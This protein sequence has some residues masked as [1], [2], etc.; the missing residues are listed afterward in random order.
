M[1]KAVLWAKGREVRSR[2]A[3]CDGLPMFDVTGSVG[4]RDAPWSVLERR[5]VAPQPHPIHPTLSSTR[6]SDVPQT[7]TKQT[8]P[9][10]FHSDAVSRASRLMMSAPRTPGYTVYAA[11]QQHVQRLSPQPSLPSEPL[12][13][14]RTDTPAIRVRPV[15]LCDDRTK[16]AT[17]QRRRAWHYWGPQTVP[18]ALP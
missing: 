18:L 16:D 4:C 8:K 12:R 13:E 14:Q 11:L 15:I 10:A 17:E 1:D 2:L 6:D 3:C 5:R 7:V 9:P